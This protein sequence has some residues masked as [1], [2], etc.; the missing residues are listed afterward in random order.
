MAILRLQVDR[1]GLDDDVPS[2][3]VDMGELFYLLGKYIQR[4]GR[5]DL[6]LRLKTRYSHLIEAALR[7]P[8]NVLT[9]S[10]GKFKNV[11]L[12]WLAEW[13]MEISGVSDDSL[14][15]GP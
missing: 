3:Q 4:L 10:A 7:K 15:H 14:V 2:V 13:S 11:A 9:A 1:M 5:S 8:D 12:D 6:F